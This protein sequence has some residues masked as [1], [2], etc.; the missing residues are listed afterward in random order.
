LAID[1]PLGKFQ[2]QIEE[3]L[4]TPLGTRL[5]RIA[6][7]VLSGGLTGVLA[8]SP[9]IAL[10]AGI[11]RTMSVLLTERAT[12]LVTERFRD[13]VSIMARELNR[14]E[15]SKIDPEYFNTEEFLT[16]LILAID[17]LQFAH[18]REKVKMLA[19][20]LT[21]S[22]R[23]QGPSDQR[24]EMFVRA[25]RD[26]TPA[27][28]QLLK[29]MR[30]GSRHVGGVVVPMREICNPVSEILMLL[31][32]LA[33]LGLVEEFPKADTPQI[34]NVAV[35]SENEVRKV[36][37]DAIFKSLPKRCFRLSRFGSDFLDFISEE[38]QAEQPPA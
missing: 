26:L 23:K 28:V 24:K 35:L 21:N 29:D 13:M 10:L 37:S 25:I 11:G 3:D 36:L 14:I 5:A 15:E 2:E 20:A 27:H 38:Q 33:G 32:N 4:N 12:K 9:R 22:C 8:A 7:S 34:S 1:D 30:D 17:Q 18:H 31:Q 6:I 16:L 19:S